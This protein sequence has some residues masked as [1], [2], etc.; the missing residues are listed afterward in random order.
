M[1][2]NH[3]LLYRDGKLEDRKVKTGLSNWEYT[4]ITSGLNAGDQVVLSLDREGVKAGARAQPD[5]T[6]GK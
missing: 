1:E 4:E 6:Q 2:G 5:T 3:V